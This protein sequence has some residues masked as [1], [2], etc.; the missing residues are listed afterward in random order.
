ME[1]RVLGPLVVVGDA[2]APIELPLGQRRAVLI[3]LLLH[4]NQPVSAEQ[5]VEEI[6]EGASP[7]T[8][9]KIVQLHISHLRRTLGR[10][11][12]DRDPTGYVLRLRPEELDAARAET[13][14]EAAGNEPVPRRIVLLREALALWRGSAL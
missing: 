11:R 12:I 10:D 1:F 13:L 14:G 2:G 5:L 8:A 6:W 4:A 7:P 3:Y 9:E